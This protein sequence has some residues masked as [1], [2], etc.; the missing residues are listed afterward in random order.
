MYDERDVFSVTQPL[1][2]IPNNCAQPLRV[3]A[4]SA[5]YRARG[6]TEGRYLRPTAAIRPHQNTPN[7]SA[8][9]ASTAL[10]FSSNS[11]LD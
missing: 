2:N 4:H 1:G 8:F 6:V 5:R 9:A 10:H 7:E 11:V 3:A